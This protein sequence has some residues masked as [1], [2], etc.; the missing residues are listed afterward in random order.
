MYNTD[1]TV[2]DYMSIVLTHECNRVCKFCVDSYRGEDVY[3]SVE[4]V[5][6]ALIFAST[7][8]I[9]DILLVGGEPT[10]HPDVVKISRLVKSYGFNLIFTSNFDNLDVIYSLDG[11]VDSF[12]FSFYGQK[13]LPDP[14][15]LSHSDLTLSSL[16]HKTGLLN[17]KEKLDAFIDKH[18]DT[19]TLKF[20]T[21]T[22]VNAFTNKVQIV[23]YL[24][25]LQDCTYL[26]LFNEILGQVYRGHV[27][28][29]Y[30]RLVNPFAKQSFKC[31]VNG[32]INQ[33]WDRDVV[34]EEA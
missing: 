16:I 13:T 8:N 19:Y 14:T 26:I 11:I 2:S 3:I 7:Q 1:T 5:E 9:K 34:L 33:S 10:L 27:I 4:N 28:K 6:K 20:A 24:D 30:D 31:H 15:K 29:R 21:L 25:E 17:S 12:N 18:Q 32:N 22:D 23:P